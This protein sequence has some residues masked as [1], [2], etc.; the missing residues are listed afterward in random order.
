VPAEVAGRLAEKAGLDLGSDETEQNRKSG[1]GALAGY[2][3][4]LGVGAAY[5]LVG[6]HLGD[7][8]KTRAGIVL[9]LAAMARCDAPAAALG[10]TEPNTSGLDS[11]VSD[12]VPHLAYGLMTAVAY[13]AFNGL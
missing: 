5:R 11:W 10:V 3:V 7:V 9:G 13:D 12:S 2:V 6:P 8:S 1:L 4:G